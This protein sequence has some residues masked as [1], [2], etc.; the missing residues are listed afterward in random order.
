MSAWCLFP[1]FVSLW[2]STGPFQSFGEKCHKRN[3]GSHW[4]NHWPLWKKAEW[5]P[6]SIF[7]TARKTK[8][9]KMTKFDTTGGPLTTPIYLCP[10]VLCPYLTFGTP[11]RSNAACKRFSNV[12]FLYNWC[13]IFSSPYVLT[14]LPLQD[15]HFG[16]PLEY[17]AVEKLDYAVAMFIES[18][19]SSKE[20]H[21]CVLFNICCNVL[22]W[23]S[24]PT[25]C[26][27]SDQFSK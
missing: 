10:S 14:L 1:S 17:V 13:H 22:K 5:G 2:S 26:Q 9:F 7:T 21:V 18:L 20:S 25:K 8:P 12:I 4:C 11:V 27:L 16:E 15:K 3:W 24:S 6:L 19:L 23:P